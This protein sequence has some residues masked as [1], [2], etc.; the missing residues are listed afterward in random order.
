M[1]DGSEKFSAKE[2]ERQKIRIT[3]NQDASPS[4]NKY[5]DNPR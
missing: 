2:N 5:P 3:Q 4:V 1:N